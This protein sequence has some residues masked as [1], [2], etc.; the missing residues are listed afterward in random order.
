[1]KNLV[2]TLCVLAMPVMVT[3]AQSSSEETL[4]VE[5]VK[6]TRSEGRLLVTMNL[7]AS[8][9]KV[10]RNEEVTFTPIIM[11]ISENKELEAIHFAGHDRHYRYLRNY[12][13]HTHLPY[14]YRA[15]KQSE[16]TYQVVVPYEKW[17]ENA[18]VVLKDS[19][20][21]CLQELLSEN[22][23]EVA[24]M[25]L[26]PM[27]FKPVFVYQAPKLEEKRRALSGS[28][29]ID[30]PVSKTEIRENYRNNPIELHK[31]Y[32]T[33]DS[34]KNDPD[35]TITGV[36]IKGH[37]SPEGSYEGNKRLAIG[38]TKSLMAHVQNLYEFPKNLLQT[39]YEPEDWEGLRERVSKSNLEHKDEIL[40]LIDNTQLNI[41]TKEHKIRALYPTDYRYLKNQVYPA[42]RHSDYT[43]SYTVRAYTDVEEAKRVMKTRPGNL[44]PYEFYKVAETYQ[45]GSDE[46][47]EIF[48]I[49]ARVYPDDELANLNAANVAMGQGELISA[50]KFLEKV[51]ESP[52]SSYAWGLLEALEGNYDEAVT[53]FNKAKE[54]GVTE[55][56]EALHQIEELK[57][58]Q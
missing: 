28:A 21:G 36:T 37:A 13:T 42:L 46:Y 12:E 26:Q 31:I 57:K 41:D 45:Q 7:D 44:S 56:E 35:A 53:Y 58:Y 27:K 55:S 8:E 22:F 10:K 33:I 29:Y 34:V 32:A 19:R 16:I 4:K 52:Q 25:H 6:V 40:K 18:Q 3:V 9:L 15:G 43:V 39:A 38:R 2:V 23:Q 54:G 20:C 49:M 50:R 17:M 11:G 47:N 14:Y 5:Q 24:T 30:Y 51:N 1:M 48:S